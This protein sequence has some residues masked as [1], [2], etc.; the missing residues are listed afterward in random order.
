MILSGTRGTVR[1]F[2][3]NA[4]RFIIIDGA[5]KDVAVKKYMMIQRQLQK[6]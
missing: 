4:A 1:G 6:F 5:L 3:R 2:V